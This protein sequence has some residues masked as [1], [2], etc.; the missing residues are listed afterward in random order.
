MLLIRWKL[1]GK[2]HLSM[3]SSLITF[4]PL[5]G[6]QGVSTA[7]G[8]EHFINQPCTQPGHFGVKMAVKPKL[9]S[10]QGSPGK[11][12]ATKMMFFNSTGEKNLVLDLMAQR[13]GYLWFITRDFKWICWGKNF[14]FRMPE[15]IWISKKKSNIFIN[16][17]HVDY[18]AGS[19]ILPL[20]TQKFQKIRDEREWGREEE[21]SFSQV[22]QRIN[23][24]VGFLKVPPYL[25]VW[26]SWRHPGLL[27]WELRAP[28]VIC[29]HF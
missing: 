24:N 18:L 11:Q 3:Q 26:P 6:L 13:K 17:C 22:T 14:M 23:Y 19:R 21:G 5:L 2:M 4:C 28:Q 16:F 12:I 7:T 29:C 1:S 20:Q 10:I 27:A 8:E 15:K 9:V 25:P